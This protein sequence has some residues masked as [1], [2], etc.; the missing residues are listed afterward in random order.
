MVKTAPKNENGEPIC[1]F[2]SKNKLYESGRCEGKIIR[3]KKAYSPFVDVGQMLANPPEGGRVGEIVEWWVYEC[4]NK[5]KLFRPKEWA[6]VPEEPITEGYYK[7]DKIKWPEDYYD[8]QI[9][10]REEMDKLR[11]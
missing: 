5:H 4:E 10:M 3:K 8:A 1:P 7:D 9:K 2:W 11:G 6:D